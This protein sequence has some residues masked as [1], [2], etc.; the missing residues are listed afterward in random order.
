MNNIIVLGESQLCNSYIGRMIKLLNNKITYVLE[1]NAIKINI[2][3]SHNF[4]IYVQIPETKNNCYL[5]ILNEY[6]RDIFANNIT[7][8]IN[9]IKSQ[10]PH[11]K[12][13]LITNNISETQYISPYIFAPCGNINS[14]GFNI[15]NDNHII[16]VTNLLL[17]QLI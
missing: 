10:D 16:D 13:I 3:E 1:P 2:N 11:Y 6:E 7:K 4:N 15:H 14:I 5:L 17:N 8:I 12:Y 9:F